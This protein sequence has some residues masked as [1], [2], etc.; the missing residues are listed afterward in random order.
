M[1]LTVSV[2]VSLVVPSMTLIGSFC[3]LS[4]FSRVVCDI[5][6]RP[7]PWPMTH[8]TTLWYWAV[9]AGLLTPLTF[10]RHRLSTLAAFTSLA[11][12]LHNGRR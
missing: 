12:S 10:A 9:K 8:R 11:Y 6:V 5:S 1:N 2:R 7:N 4:S 3:T